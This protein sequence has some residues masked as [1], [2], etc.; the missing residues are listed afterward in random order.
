MQ[1][2][3]RRAR[4]VDEEAYLTAGGRIELDLFADGA[5]TRWLGIAL[6]ERLAEKLG[7]LAPS[8]ASDAA[9]GWV[10]PR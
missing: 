5:A 7:A 10:R 2:A 3:D 1:L 4:I 9:L 8:L 6:L